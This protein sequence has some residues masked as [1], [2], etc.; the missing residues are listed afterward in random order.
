M[1]NNDLNRTT[2]GGS[3]NTPDFV[4]DDTGYTPYSDSGNDTGNNS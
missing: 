2:F 4:Y 1:D 3:D